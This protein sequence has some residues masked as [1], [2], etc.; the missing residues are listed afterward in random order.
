MAQIPS[1]PGRER[2][3][4]ASAGQ[5]AGLGVTFAAAI[6]LFTLGGNWVDKRLGTE[7]WGVLLGVMLGFGLGLAWIYRRL[8]VEPRARSRERE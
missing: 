1:G 2:P 8:V 3:D 6:V 5:Y 4:V 7:P